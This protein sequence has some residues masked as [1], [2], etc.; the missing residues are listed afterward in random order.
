MYKGEGEQTTELTR[1][2]LRL[3]IPCV[4]MIRLELTT[5]RP[6]DVYANQL[7][8][9]PIDLLACKDTKIRLSEHNKSLFLLSKV[10]ILWKLFTIWQVTIYY[11]LVIHVFFAAVRALFSLFFLTLHPN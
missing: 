2:E 9:I 1:C 3:R 10:R 11:F 5:T 7:R 6:P 4:G 8:Y